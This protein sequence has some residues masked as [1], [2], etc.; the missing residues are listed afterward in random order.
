LPV[1]WDGDWVPVIG[2]GL[3]KGRIVQRIGR[4][5]DSL[6]A[7]GVG[8]GLERIAC[9]KYGIDDLREVESTRI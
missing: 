2:W 7:V 3:M 8:M 5:P 6:R 4:D 1:L 9:L